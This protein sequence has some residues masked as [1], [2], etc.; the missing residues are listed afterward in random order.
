MDIKR[1]E[2]RDSSMDLIRIVAVF[3][4]MSVHFLYHTYTNNPAARSAVL[5]DDFHENAVFRLRASVHDFDG[6]FA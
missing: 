5:P 6:L 3:L 1:L 4:V 2:R